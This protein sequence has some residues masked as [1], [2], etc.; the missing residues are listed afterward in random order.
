MENNLNSMTGV[1]K[2]R[3]KTVRSSSYPG[4]I[5]SREQAELNQEEQ[6][7]LQDCTRQKRKAN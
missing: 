2:N 1:L 4:R 6:E 3:M 5:E 7:Q